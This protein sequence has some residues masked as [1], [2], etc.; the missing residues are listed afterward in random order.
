MNGGV[1]WGRPRPGRGCRAIDGWVGGWIKGLLKN[2]IEF[3][4]HNRVL[5]STLVHLA[6]ICKWVIVS[7]HV[8]HTH[9]VHVYSSTLPTPN[10]ITSNDMIHGTCIRSNDP[11]VLSIHRHKSLLQEATRYQNMYIYRQCICATA[12]HT[13]FEQYGLSYVLLTVHL[14]II[15]VNNQLDTEFFFIY[16]YFYSLHVSGSHVP[17]VRRINCINT[18]SGICHSV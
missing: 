14:D 17:I 11:T 1:L 10:V 12:G 2:R 3:I 5:K 8:P 9:T 7:N 6:S 16:V 4:V 18:T 13:C 15:F